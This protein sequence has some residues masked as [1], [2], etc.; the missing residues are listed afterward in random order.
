MLVG[1]GL[2]RH[3]T[4][5]GN[6]HLHTSMEV[7]AALLALIVGSLALVRFYAQKNT[8]FLF[9]GTGFIGTGLLDGY[10]ALV[11][12]SY[13]SAHFPSKLDSLIPWS[14][15]SSRVFLS[16]MLC[17]SWV[18]WRRE[19][20]LGLSGRVKD[21]TVYLMAGL[22]TLAIFLFF[23][24]VPLPS[25]YYRELIFHRP[26]EFVPAFFFL[27]ALIG[28][29]RKGLWRYN[30]FEHWLVLSLIV[31]CISQA[32]FMSL[33]GHVFDTM[34]DVAHLLKQLSY[35]LVLIGLIAS[36]YR[37]F[38][39][40]ENNAEEVKTTNAALQKKIVQ[41]QL[42][43]EALG[44]SEELN[45]VLLIAIP[46][47]M[48]RVNGEGTFV[49]F[50][51]ASGAKPFADPEL[52]LGQNITDVL[53]NEVAA[54][55]GSAVEQALATADIQYCDFKL[56]IEGELRDFDARIVTISPVETLLITRDIDR[57]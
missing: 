10:H 56:S 15:I 14:W 39:Q 8:L 49:D 44:S 16:I 1:F 27:L 51:P 22:M 28:Y 40:E 23:A 18:A 12:S 9:I 47:L 52:F 7:V 48:Y 38:I 29:L 57:P 36:M 19:S 53:P 45:Q 5:Q 32:V 21:R 17:L 42:A 20:R 6:I 34:F 43:E 41:H 13:F 50:I 4:W 25:A 54:K 11:T 26:E 55:V 31:S 35:I 37:L 46:D 30:K 2:I 24:F 33:S 3:S